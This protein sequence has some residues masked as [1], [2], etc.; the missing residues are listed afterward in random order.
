MANL[1]IGDRAISF[2]LLAVD[3]KEHSLNDYV[4]K[5][6]VAVIFSCNHCPY[7]RAW[8]DRMVQIQSDYTDKGVQL[9]AINSNDESKYPDDSFAKMKD[10]ARDKKFNFPYL[11]DETQNVARAYGAERTPEVFLFD[12]NSILQY[13]GTID[14]NYD[15]PKAVKEHY[16]RRAL[17]SVL[18]GKSVSTRET[19]PV[20]CTIKWK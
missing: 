5:N 16:L 20:G 10:R 14:D 7:V 6:A 17:D 3:D 13:H 8:E 2:K 11:R 15:D 18:A 19:K 9:V 4:G 12:R 1:R